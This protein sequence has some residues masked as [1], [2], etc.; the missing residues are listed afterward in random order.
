MTRIENAVSELYEMDELAMMSSP[1]HRLSAPVKLFCTICYILTVMSF[2]K[3]DLSGVIVMVWYPLFVS[4]L[5]GIPLSLGIHKLRWILPLVIAVGIF[6]PFFD[7]T[8]VFALGRIPVTAG[9]I[10]MLVIMLKGVLCLL[11]SFL[12]AA[13]TRSDDLFASFRIFRIPSFLITLL[14]LTYRYIGAFLEEVSVMM[15]S[16][17]LRAPEQKGVHFSAW[18]SFLGQLLLRTIDRADGLYS[19]ML[20]RGY[21][22][23]FPLSSH[24]RTHAHD[25]LAAFVC[26]FLI[27]FCR[28]GDPAGRI[29][30]FLG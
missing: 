7:R 16:Y 3:Y 6:N 13:S 22:G 2:G 20:L 11:A 4:S 15:T 26:L 24:Q 28:F 1:V 25:I 30:S 17:Q 19:A 5:S 9:I 18:G 21:D 14:M 10:S 12:L 8:V 27:L 23:S 29:G